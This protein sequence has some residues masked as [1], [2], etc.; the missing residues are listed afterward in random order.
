MPA[1][2]LPFVVALMLTLL[3]VNLFVR[4]SRIYNAA[5]VF[6]AAMIVMVTLVGLRW[7]TSLTFV[8]WLQPFCASLMPL[9]AWRC[10][11][12][13]TIPARGRFLLMCVLMTLPVALSQ[14]YP[15]TSMPDAY[16]AALT[17]FYGVRLIKMAANGPDRF[18]AFR[19][20]EAEVMTHSAMLAGALLCGSAFTDLLITAD[21]ALFN[22]H[23]VTLLI[24]GAQMLVM[25]ALAT[26]IARITPMQ[27]VQD[28]EPTPASPPDGA[29][30]IPEED[31]AICAQIALLIEEKGLFRDP[32]LT[33]ERLARKSLIPARRVSQ[34]INRVQQRNV[35]Q[36]I[37]SYRVRE[38]Q[39][40]LETT[41]LPIT[42][43]MAEAGF[44]TKS[45]FNRE[46]LRLT[47]KNPQSWRQNASATASL[48]NEGRSA[49]QQEK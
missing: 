29:V 36:M 11:C 6:L 34:A 49:P 39:R 5:M 15:Q 47:G 46:F 48:E 9:L 27:P 23:H 2:P 40:L 22:G 43:I 32:D 38:A 24:A 31:H 33:L 18:S 37:N 25:L 4:R 12:P 26:I 17:L 7:N 28:A 13:V 45:N 41:T 10:F 8:H 30:V 42:E 44:R 3:L 19:L 14:L 16:I 1:I 20:S 21:I 35:S